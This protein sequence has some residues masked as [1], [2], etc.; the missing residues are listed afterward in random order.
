MRRYEKGER[1]F[2]DGAPWLH[3]A[4]VTKKKTWNTRTLTSYIF[5]IENTTGE[6]SCGWILT[7]PPCLNH[8]FTI[9]W[10][11]RLRFRQQSVSSG[12]HGYQGSWDQCI[13]L[14][15]D[16]PRLSDLAL[17]PFGWLGRVTPLLGSLFFLFSPIYFSAV[18]LIHPPPRWIVL[19]V[20]A[21]GPDISP[22]PS[23]SAPSCTHFKTHTLHNIDTQTHRYGHPYSC[24]TGKLYY[25]LI[26]SMSVHATP[27]FCVI[28][29]RAQHWPLW[30]LNWSLLIC[31]S[32][33]LPLLPFFSLCA[34]FCHLYTFMWLLVAFSG[35]SKPDR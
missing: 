19:P 33:C 13:F 35:N 11:L 16:D 15:S 31:L 3:L 25:T 30:I 34:V 28:V 18:S 23:V 26:Y 32:S 29:W 7:Y 20:S 9:L 22:L 17:P 12:G 2:W 1:V 6:E 5:T 4:H 10:Q 8:Y 14:L 24:F 21:L 27:T